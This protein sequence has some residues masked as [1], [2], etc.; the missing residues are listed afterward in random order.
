MA[1]TRTGDKPLSE[2]MMVCLLTHLCVTRRAL[3]KA[4]TFSPYMLAKDSKKQIAMKLHLDS[5]GFH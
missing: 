3:G 5:K 4:I 1:L 2:P